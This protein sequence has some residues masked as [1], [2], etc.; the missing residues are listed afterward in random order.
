MRK[1]L[2]CI[3]S[4]I[5]IL[6]TVIIILSFTPKSVIMFLCALILSNIGVF[7]FNFA[8]G[9][10]KLNFSTIIS[11]VFITFFVVVFYIKRW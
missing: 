1:K 3:I 9:D 4:G 2:I 5:V 7:L 10:F 8:Q 6:I 11:Q